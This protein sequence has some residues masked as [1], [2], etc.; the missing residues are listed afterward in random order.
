MSH[1]EL[2][3]YENA[4]VRTMKKVAFETYMNMQRL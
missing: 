1:F 2:E 4:N 3:T